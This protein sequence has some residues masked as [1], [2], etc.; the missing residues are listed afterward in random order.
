MILGGITLE[1]VDSLYQRMGVKELFILPWYED[2]NDEVCF[3][4]RLAGLITG[5]IEEMPGW[6]GKTGFLEHFMV[7]PEAS[8]PLA[9][10]QQMPKE[11]ARLLRARGDVDRILLCID[12]EHPKRRGLDAWARRCGY[13]KYA[14]HEG[15]S[16][17]VHPLFTIK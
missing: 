16:W 2:D 8:N 3:G 14:V 5:A 7:L 10:M 15:R 11:A 6:P 1:E 9:V 13:T 12:E 4:R 17:Y